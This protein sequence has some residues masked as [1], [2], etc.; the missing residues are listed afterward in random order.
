M[1]V[2]YMYYNDGCSKY[3]PISV[4]RVIYFSWESNAI[5]GKYDFYKP[6]ITFLHSSI[7]PGFNSHLLDYRSNLEQ[8]HT[9]MGYIPGGQG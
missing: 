9:V 5:L 7:S 1:A 3:T 2:D 4:P 8:C 6:I